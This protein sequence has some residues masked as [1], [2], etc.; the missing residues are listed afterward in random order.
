[1]VD[2]HGFRMECDFMV[3]L[4]GKPAVRF[5]LPDLQG[6]IHRLEQY[7]GRWLLLMFHRHLG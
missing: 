1:M 4:E 7:T 2:S 5:E 6:R 3:K